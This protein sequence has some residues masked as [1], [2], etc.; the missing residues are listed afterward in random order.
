MGLMYAMIHSNKIA[1]AQAAVPAAAQAA[2][3]PHSAMEYVFNYLDKWYAARKFKENGNKLVFVADG[4][5]DEFQERVVRE[6]CSK[7]RE[8]ALASLAELLKNKLDAGDI[9][10]VLRRLRWVGQGR[11]WRW[12]GRRRR[13][14]GAQRPQSPHR[15]DFRLRH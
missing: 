14:Q 10:W 15:G 8:T 2:V 3:P 4:L 9:A 6:G 5:P 11:Y 1:A 12:N 7:P 13:R